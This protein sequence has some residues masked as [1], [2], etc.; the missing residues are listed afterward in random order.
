[1][2]IE[3][4]PEEPEVTPEPTTEETPTPAP[5]LSEQFAKLSEELSSIKESLNQKQEM[6]PP[7]GDESFDP[8]DWN[9]VWGK[10][11]EPGLARM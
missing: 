3:E 5:D 8:K 10:V 4:T 6:T 2:L 1:M 11:E 9:D 7:P